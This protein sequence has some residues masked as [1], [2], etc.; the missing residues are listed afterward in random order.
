MQITNKL[1]PDLYRRKTYKD[2]ELKLKFHKFLL[3]TKSYEFK[4]FKTYL[5]ILKL[6]QYFWNIHSLKK[7]IRKNYCII[8]KRSKS[9]YKKFKI[10]R[11]QIKYLAGKNVL[12][13]LQKSS[14]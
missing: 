11:I 3:F 4:T 5:K 8:T 12:P 13:G 14:W 6:N 10:S 9:I 1:K 2:F 7:I